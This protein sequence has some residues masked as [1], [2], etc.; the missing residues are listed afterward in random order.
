MNAPRVALVLSAA[1]TAGPAALAAE[2][3]GVRVHVDATTVGTPISPYIYGQFT[4]HLGRCI[5]G[6]LWSEMLEDRKF[7][8]P[9]T[10]EAPAWEMFQPGKSS[11]EGAGVPYELSSSSRVLLSSRSPLYPLPIEPGARSGA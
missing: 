9:V 10:G 4:E 6:G 1:L 11:Y 7:F 2:P 3:G 8:Y 5:Y